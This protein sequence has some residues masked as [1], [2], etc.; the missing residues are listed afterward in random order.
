MEKIT[1]TFF[2][3][4]QYNNLYTYSYCFQ[5][6]FSY[7][8]FIPWKYHLDSA[9]PFPPKH[10]TLDSY[11]IS[12]NN[13][14]YFCRHIYILM[15]T[16]T[17][18][19]VKASYAALIYSHTVLIPSYVRPQAIYCSY[20]TT[21]IDFL[22]LQVKSQP[23]FVTPVRQKLPTLL[24]YDCLNDLLLVLDALRWLERSF[25]IGISSLS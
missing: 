4:V 10:L 3:A 25:E 14:Q 22:A 17:L 5:S 1:E 8:P 9:N 24:N 23:L 18:L 6:Y 16:W 13:F 7:S 19:S 12:Y 2:V 21:T 11:L 15:N 20:N